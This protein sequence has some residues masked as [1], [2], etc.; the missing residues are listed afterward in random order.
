MNTDRAPMAQGSP[1]F[2]VAR[3]H[4]SG[5]PNRFPHARHSGPPRTRSLRRRRYTPEPRVS[6]VHR[7]PPSADE[8]GR[9][10]TLGDAPPKNT[11][12]TPKALHK[13]HDHTPTA[14]GVRHWRGTRTESQFGGHASPQRSHKLLDPPRLNR[15]QRATNPPQPSTS[16][17]PVFRGSIRPFWVAGEARVM[18]K[19][20]IKSRSRR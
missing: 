16:D 19:S 9:S 11:F 12:L 14:F 10:A 7:S 6:A 4:N 20:K 17:L 18:I 13:K 1:E 2:S 3:H 8:G 15:Y 5:A